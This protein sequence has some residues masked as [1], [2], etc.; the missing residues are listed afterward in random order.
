ML[1]RYKRCNT[2]QEDLGIA[3]QL[4]EGKTL[5]EIAADLGTT[6]GIVSYRL[7]KLQHRL[8]AKSKIHLISKLIV[9]FHIFPRVSDSHVQ[10]QNISE[11][12]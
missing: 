2:R 6:I 12:L 11:K 3:Q 5:K 1:T 4:A 7:E 8:G 9:N 10:P